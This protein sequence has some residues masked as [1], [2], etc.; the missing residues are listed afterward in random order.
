MAKTDVFVAVK[1]CQKFHR[2]RGENSYN[3]DLNELMDVELP[4]YTNTCV[5]Q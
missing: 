2:D 3:K 1:T 4:L 5:S